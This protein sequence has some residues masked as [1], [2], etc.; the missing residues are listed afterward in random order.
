MKYNNS[1]F[2]INITVCTKIDDNYDD[3]DEEEEVIVHIFI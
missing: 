3:G 2:H 1:L